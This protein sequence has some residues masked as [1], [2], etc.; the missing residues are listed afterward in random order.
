MQFIRQIIAQI[1]QKRQRKA[2]RKF[3]TGICSSREFRDIH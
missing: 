1:S 2:C 3:S